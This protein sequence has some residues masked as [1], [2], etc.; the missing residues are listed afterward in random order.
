MVPVPTCHFEPA[1][2]ALFLEFDDLVF[3]YFNLLVSAQVKVEDSPGEALPNSEIFRRLAQAMHYE[4]PELFEL[5]DAADAALEHAARSWPGLWP[6]L[7]QARELV[8]E[9]RAA[10]G[11]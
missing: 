7:E 3:P 4:E 2:S 11:R 5:L 9:G 6:E 10:R 1:D 8:R